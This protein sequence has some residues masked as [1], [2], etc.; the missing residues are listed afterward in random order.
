[1]IF[2]VQ[3]NLIDIGKRR[4]HHHPLFF[5]WRE[6]RSLPVNHLNT[7]SRAGHAQDHD[8]L[9]VGYREDRPA[10]LIFFSSIREDLEQGILVEDGGRHGDMDL[11]AAGSLP[12]RVINQ[13]CRTP[14]K[15][16]LLDRGDGIIGNK[17]RARF[18]QGKTILRHGMHKKQCG[19][20]KG[21][22]DYCENQRRTTLPEFVRDART[23]F[24]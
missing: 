11:T 23:F 13:I 14:D 10:V 8:A 4:D 3:I 2:R 6:F 5:K 24:L 15:I 18:K 17:S 9:I 22:Y 20:M 16:V 21:R 19:R 7:G 12:V 1:M